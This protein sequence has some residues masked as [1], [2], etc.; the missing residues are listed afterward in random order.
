MKRGSLVKSQFIKI[1]N[2]LYYLLSTKN[3]GKI[4]KFIDTKIF[5]L[6]IFKSTQNSIINIIQIFYKG[7]VCI[8][9]KIHTPKTI[10]M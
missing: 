7:N 10:R 3:D 8:Y 6:I 1:N 4:Y 2:T 5:R 9:I